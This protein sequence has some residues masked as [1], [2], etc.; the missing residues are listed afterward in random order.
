MK[1]NKK[2]RHVVVMG[3]GNI[4]LKDDGVGI[5]ALRKLQEAGSFPENIEVEIID[6]GTTSDISVFLDSSVDK[7]IIIDAVQ[8]HGKTGA[9]YRFTPDVFES[10]KQDITS[11]HYL[12][13]K[14]CMVF[15]RLSGIYPEE[16][17]IIGVEPG[18][19]DWGMNLTSEVESRL[20]ELLSIL[21]R[22]ITF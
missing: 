22:E 7:I 15:M 11:V 4:L 17:I 20:P 5:H 3:I 1:E 21:R 18:E 19:M 12:N 2:I 16:V 9:I 8:A 13:L 14:E 6:C 10:E